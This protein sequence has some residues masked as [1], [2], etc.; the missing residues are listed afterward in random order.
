MSG[1]I[2]GVEVYI[3]EVLKAIFEQG[4]EHEFVLWTNASRRID[5]SHL[6]WRYPRVH[7]KHTRIPN[8]LLNLSTSLFRWPKIDRLIGGKID[9]LWVPNLAPAPVSEKVR[10]VITFH[11]LSFVDFA[12]AFS[13]KARLWHRLIRPKKEALEAAHLIAV[14][15]F[16]KQR[17]VEEYGIPESRIAVTYEA[18]AD[19]L[20]PLS[21]P[22]SFDLVRRKY[23]LPERYFLCLSTLE[24][25]KNIA[26]VIQAY[27]QWHQE[28][29]SDV[30][31]VIAGAKHPQIF[32]R[33]KLQHHP[34]V[35]MTGF[36]EEA[37]KA[38][39]YQHALAFLYPSFYEGF[40]LPILEAMQCGAPVIT[41]DCAG[42]AEVAGEAAVLVNPNDFHALKQALHKFYRDETA[43]ELYVQKGLQHVQKFSWKKTAAETYR[44]LTSI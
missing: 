4:S 17:L 36:V 29:K 21:I 31:L 25:R 13:F 15:F 39:L 16:T 26:G 28:V 22:R 35:I 6:G 20:K 41:S 18:A 3:Q 2:S 33:Y 38:L 7:F 27:L 11:D 8:I 43:R 44:I 10:K 40:G 5:F 14:S 34:D 42:M 30:K 37:D 19:H 12:H 1:K 9:V 32:A 23:N 24:P